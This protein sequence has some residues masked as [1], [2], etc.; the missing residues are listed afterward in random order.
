LRIYAKCLVGQDGLARR[1]IAE[2]L[3]DDSD[4]SD[5]GSGR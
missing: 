5:K 3:Q 1:R 4:D 2:A